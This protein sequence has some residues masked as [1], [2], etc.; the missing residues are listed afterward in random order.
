MVGVFAGASLP[1][2]VGFGVHGALG[3]VAVL[4]TGALVD[5][6]TP[7]QSSYFL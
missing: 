5:T 1:V 6:V 2:S 3:G 7:F 4:L